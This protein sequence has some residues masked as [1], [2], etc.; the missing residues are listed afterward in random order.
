MR[1][2]LRDAASGKWRLFERPCEL[3]VARDVHEVVPALQKIEAECAKGVYAAGFIA[4][5]AAPAFDS[6]LRTKADGMFPLLWFGLYDG[7]H[8]LPGETVEESAEG[9][10]EVHG[11]QD[12]APSIDASQYAFIFGRL[13]DLVRRGQ[14]YQVNFTYRLKSCMPTSPWAL[15]QRLVAAQEPGFGAYLHAGEWIVC[16]A[17]PELFFAKDGA[18]IYS[19]PMK[20]TAARGLWYEDDVAQAEALS[21]SEKERAENVMIVD[22][23][24]NDLGRIARQGTVRVSRLFDLERYP[25]MWQMTSTVSAETD[26][27]LTEVMAALFPPA[28]VTGAPKASTMAIIAELECSPRRIYT[29]TVGFIDPGG[30]AQFNVAIR[31]ALINRK[32]GEAEY[33]AG[34]GIV[35]DSNVDREMAEARLKSKVLCASRPAFDLLETML[36]TPE[37][38]FLLLELHLKRLLQ[39]A[40]YFAFHL[41]L[42]SVRQQLAE[43]ADTFNGTARRVR[44]VV[45]K[46]GAVQLTATCQTPD[47]GRFAD[48]ALAGEPID[49]RDPFLY[50]KTTNREAYQH[51]LASRP[52]ADDVLLFNEKNQV[53]E[54]TIAN[55]VFELELEGRLFTPPIECGLLAGT[56]RAQLLNEGRIG[57]RTIKVDELAM[58]PRLYLLN[59]VRG[60]QAVSLTKLVRA[61]TPL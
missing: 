20:G 46:A 22:M 49:S 36:W 14:T 3:V 1:A 54:S 41:S 4:Y 34:G 42:Q 26:A 16:S 11:T 18:S 37:A 21:Q 44:M 2:I 6:A 8:D 9:R 38:G 13:Q 60:M 43:L 24:R 7:F 17:S 55:L 31:T 35:A 53:T 5:E 48:M 57:E 29:G 33:G 59:S 39:S 30:R 19:K 15:F 10:R 32:T 51:A 58:A 45:S 12:W 40:E 47:A 52:G 56:A 61:V 25:A 27:A 50:H 23:V 28:S